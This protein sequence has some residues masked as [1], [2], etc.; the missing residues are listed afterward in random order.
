MLHSIKALR[1]RIIKFYALSSKSC[2]CKINKRLIHNVGLNDIP[3]ISLTDIRKLLRQKG[4]A[5][6]DGYTSFI[7]KCTICSGDEKKG[8][9]KVYVNKT[10]G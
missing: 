1:W 10:T 5:V 6:Q 4:L 7:T 2:D 8:D 9:S 3:K